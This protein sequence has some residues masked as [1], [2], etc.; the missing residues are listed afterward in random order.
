MAAGVGVW[1]PAVAGVLLIYVFPDEA[2]CESSYHRHVL[3][4][5]AQWFSGH[6]LCKLLV[7]SWPCTAY[8]YDFCQLNGCGRLLPAVVEVWRSTLK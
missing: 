6:G 7:Y 1:M 8:P 5:L 2:L 3:W 4:E